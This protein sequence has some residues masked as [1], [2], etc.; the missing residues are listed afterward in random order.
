MGGSLLENP[1]VFVEEN[2]FREGRNARPSMAPCPLARLA[3]PWALLNIDGGDYIGRSPRW[4]DEVAPGVASGKAWP[5]GT[6]VV[7]QKPAWT[8]REPAIALALWGR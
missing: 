7:E 4:Q 8:I 5:L 2:P 3:N 6:A 1:G